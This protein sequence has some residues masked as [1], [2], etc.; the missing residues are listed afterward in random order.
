M[1]EHADRLMDQIRVQRR[2]KELHRQRADAY[3]QTIQTLQSSVERLKSSELQT[4]THDTY[5]KREPVP[6]RSKCGRF[7]G[8][9]K[10]ETVEDQ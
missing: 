7:H 4:T 6:M 2:G 10:F 3:K 9:V 1:K 8:E 5:D